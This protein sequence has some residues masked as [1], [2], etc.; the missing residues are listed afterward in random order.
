MARTP[1]IQLEPNTTLYPVPVVII[2]CG[3]GEN[4]NLFTLNRIA[5]CNAEPPLLSISVRPARLSHQLIDELGEFVVNIPYPDAEFLADYV[6]S[7]TGR[8]VDKWRETGLTPL[9]AGQVQAP[10]VAECPVNIECVVRQRIN[11]PSHTLFIAEAVAMHAEASVLNSRHEVDFSHAQGLP[12]RSGPV[13]ERPVD[14]FRPDELLTRVHSW[15]DTR[16]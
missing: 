2:S 3:F 16:R 5:S 10:L 7:T 13:R 1:R 4:A 6:G 15:R 12:Y 8:E 14:N 9:P 11:L